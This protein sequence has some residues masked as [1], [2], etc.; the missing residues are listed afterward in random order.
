MHKCRP[1]EKVLIVELGQN[2]PKLML[3]QYQAFI[4]LMENLFLAFPDFP[5]KIF[6]GVK[7][8]YSSNIVSNLYS[9]KSIVSTFPGGLYLC[10]SRELYSYYYTNAI[11]QEN[12]EEL[13]TR[14][15]CRK[16]KIC[17]S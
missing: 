5:K 9:C 10:M 15:L 12:Q 3:D 7:T 1:P 11:S 2:K 13:E 8:L 17:L 4:P 16:D 6:S 14:F